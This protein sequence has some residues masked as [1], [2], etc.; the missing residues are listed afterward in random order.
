ML[1]SLYIGATGLYAQQL[2]VDTIANNIA[3][4]NTP[5]FKK[6]NVNFQDLMY[7]ELSKTT[8]TSGAQQ[9]LQRSGTGVGVANAT[10]SFVAGD[11]KETDAPLDLAI[12]GDGF[13]EVTLP[14]GSL[15]YSRGGSLQITPDGLLATPE[16][17]PLRAAIH[18]P[19]DAQKLSIASDG[20]VMVTTSSNATPTA[21]GQIELAKFANSG[22]L[23]PLGNNLYR[24]NESSGDPI[25]GKAGADG[26]GQLAQGFLEMS[27]VKLNDEMVNLMVAQRAYE[28]NTKLIQAA[29]ELMSMSNNLRRGG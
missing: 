8:A 11:I 1:E 21:L 2:S 12:R 17:Y 22:S 28:V 24:A 4:L 3:N 26:F 29:D 5:G 16:G 6:S 20:T 10:K 27:N 23:K 7:R 15:A 9:V 14:D 18:V 13:I 19:S 25:Y